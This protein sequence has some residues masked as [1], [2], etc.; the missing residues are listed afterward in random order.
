VVVEGA[1]VEE[2]EE[3]DKVEDV[4]E[5]DVHDPVELFL[6]QS[7]E[8]KQDLLDVEQQQGLDERNVDHLDLVFEEKQ[9]LDQVE[10]E[11]LKVLEESNVAGP[12][13]KNNERPQHLVDLGDVAF[14]HKVAALGKGVNGVDC[15]LD[16]IDSG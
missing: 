14:L 16:K 3:T 7:Q 4:V 2:Q 8:I 11:L 12:H 10:A 1:A 9:F 6:D 15:L 5:V 13:H